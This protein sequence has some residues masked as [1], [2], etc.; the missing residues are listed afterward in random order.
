MEGGREGAR[1]RG[2]EGEREGG[3]EEGGGKDDDHTF[4]VKPLKSGH[5][6]NQ[7]TVNHSSTY[8]RSSHSH[9]QQYYCQ[10]HSRHP[11]TCQPIKKTKRTPQMNC[12]L[13][14]QHLKD[15][16]CENVST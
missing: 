1:E 9:I 2:R 11:K 8:D 13:H 10:K 12:T 5:L 16:L 4:Y 15:N 14:Q 7:D 3:R 6:T